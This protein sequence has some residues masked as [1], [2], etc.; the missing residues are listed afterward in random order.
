MKKNLVAA[1]FSF[2]AF[3][4]MNA[5][6]SDG[7][8]NFIGTITGTGC[9]SSVESAGV[10]TGDV[11]MGNV[12]KT[13]FGGVGSTATGTASA[14][15]FNILLTNCPASVATATVK[16][17]GTPVNGDNSIIALT[18]ESGVAD[19]VG[20]Q[21]SDSTGVLSIG[22]ASAPYS[23]TSGSATNTLPFI[24]RYIQTKSTVVEG[25]ANSVVTFTV[26]Y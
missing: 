9:D 21:L 18:Q 7:T 4:A 6:A 13:A 2:T 1:L 24:A 22:T 11:N 16:F 15:A 5:V 19:G 14:T 26:N 23:I 8:V 3:G 10:T 12:A 25:K 17:D 20:I